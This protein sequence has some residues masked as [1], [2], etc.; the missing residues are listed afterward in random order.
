M[1]KRIRIRN[2]QRHE[3]LKIRF[4]PQITAIVGPSDVGKSSI[5]R[6]IRWVATNRPLGDGFIRYGSKSTAVKLWSDSGQVERRR[7]S[8]NTYT[9]D[10]KVLE[11]FGVEVP[12]DVLRV[13]KIDSVNFQGQHESPFW[14]DLS[15]GDVAKQ[16]NAIVDLSLIDKT[17]KKLNSRL[18]TAKAELSVCQQRLEK[19]SEEHTSLEWIEDVNVLLI[20]VESL[21]KSCGDL[22]VR[23]GNLKWAISKA[24]GSLLESVRLNELVLLGEAAVRVGLVSKQDW[25][26]IE[27]LNELIVAARECQDVLDREIPDLTEIDRL[28]TQAAGARDRTSVLA[29]TV[30]IQG[31][32]A[33][34]V[35]EMSAGLKRAERKL[36]DETGDVCPLCGNYMGPLVER[37]GD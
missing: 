15:P 31:D 32:L 16:L 14:F 24:D 34:H 20:K 12:G 33:C 28:A 30:K 2:F 21:E 13:L 27:Y 4:D 17:M 8:V 26:K 29:S 9:V 11:A 35:D 7:G 3:D 18:R 25:K 37:R 10:T 6:A 5:L 23:I 36:K 19:A 22:V 1:L